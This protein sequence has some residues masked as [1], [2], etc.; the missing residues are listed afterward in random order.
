MQD[1]HVKSLGWEGPLE[2][3]MA[4]HSSILAWR[5]PRTVDYSLVGYSLWGCKESETTEPL[6]FTTNVMSVKPRR[7][8]VLR[9][10]SGKSCQ[11][12]LEGLGR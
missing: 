11:M 1:T 12:L 4:T 6:T 9:G 3:R 5:I 8:C 7:K 2:N 10:K